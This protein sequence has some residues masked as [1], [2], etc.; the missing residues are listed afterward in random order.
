MPAVP[1]VPAMA[2]A[3]PSMCPIS[4]DGP[5]AMRHRQAASGAELGVLGVHACR[6]PRHVWDEFGTQPHRIGRA[7]LAGLVAALGDGWVE[8]SKKRDDRQHQPA[9]ETHGP[10]H[11]FLSLVS[12][13]LLPDGVT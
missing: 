12:C 10:Q 5:V 7:S 4:V 11:R 3:P 2:V 8:D 1:V 6:D 9:N 13:G